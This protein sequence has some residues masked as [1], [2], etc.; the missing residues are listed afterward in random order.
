MTNI[1]DIKM[2]FF[3]RK[4]KVQKKKKVDKNWQTGSKIGKLGLLL[5]FGEVLPF[6]QGWGGGRGE[7]L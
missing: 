3:P 6:F 4:K 7:D 2:L 5:H 1:P